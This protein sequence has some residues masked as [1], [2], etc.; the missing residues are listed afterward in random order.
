MFIYNYHNKVSWKCFIIYYLSHVVWFTSCS[1]SACVCVCVCVSLFYSPIWY[2][3]NFSLHSQVLHCYNYHVLY[4]HA[5]REPSDA[6]DTM[7]FCCHGNQRWLVT[8]RLSESAQFLRCPSC[9]KSGGRTLELL[10]WPSG[11]LNTSTSP[12][13]PEKNNKIKL[14]SHK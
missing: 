9:I 1:C 14:K 5:C 11:M 8:V 12:E 10:C 4:C 13:I 2:V 7:P 3:F 6:V